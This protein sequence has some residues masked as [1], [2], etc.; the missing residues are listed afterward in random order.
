MKKS[1]NHAKY[2]NNDPVRKKLLTR[3]LRQLTHEVIAVHPK[4]IADAGCGEGF[5]VG[6]L[7]EAGVKAEMAGVDLSKEAVRIANQK[8]PKATFKVGSIYDLPFKDDSYDLVLCN[9]VLEHLE[10]PA[11]AVKELK[12]V[13]KKYV[14]CSVPHEPF[15]MVGSLAGGKYISRL[16]NHPEHINHWT[17]IS[18]RRFLEKNGLHV[19]KTH[20]I[21]TFPW[22]LAVCTV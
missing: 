20:A 18:F 21:M 17:N 19:V 15:F 9:E 10:K 4:T 22:T 12:R 16:G 3:F 14:I 1:T 7:M 2:E 11:D 6:Q 5:V 8:F 13:S